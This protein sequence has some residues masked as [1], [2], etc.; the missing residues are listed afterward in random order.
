MRVLTSFDV[1]AITHPTAARASPI[2]R[3][4]LRPKISDMRP[5]RGDMTATPRV[6]V[7]AIQVVFGLGPI[8]LLIDCKIV[9]DMMTTKTS[10]M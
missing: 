9:E 4:F 1:A 7:I 3:K 2:K 5:A 8:A 10:A 6:G